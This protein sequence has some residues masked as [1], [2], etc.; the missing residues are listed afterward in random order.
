MSIVH[1]YIM[2]FDSFLAIGLVTC[3]QSMGV[4][5]PQGMRI[6]MFIHKKIIMIQKH[7]YFDVHPVLFFLKVF[8]NFLISVDGG[9]WIQ[10]H[11]HKDHNNT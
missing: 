4:L 10:Q 5:R 8:F 1:E 11:F 2:G 6:L 7:M 3:M 9:W